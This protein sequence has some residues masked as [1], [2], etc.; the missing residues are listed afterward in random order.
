MIEL[1]IEGTERVDAGLI[2]RELIVE[3]TLFG[4]AVDQTACAAATKEQRIGAAQNFDLFQ[5]IERAVILNIVADTIDEEVGCRADPAEDDCVA[6]AFAL[7]AIHAGR[8][9]NDL[10]DRGKATNGDLIGRHD[11]EALRHV[12]NR[13]RRA[14]RIDL[15]RVEVLT[16]HDDLVIERSR[17]G[18]G[19]RGGQKWRQCGCEQ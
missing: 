16:R 15:I 3:L 17:I 11:G 19:R 4:D 10:P 2:A 18:E 5:I 8:I 13:R 9:V 6:V 12:D 1:N 14:K 7:R